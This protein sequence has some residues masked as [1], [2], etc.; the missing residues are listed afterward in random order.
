MLFDVHASVE[1]PVTVSP[2]ASPATLVT[3]VVSV[4]PYAFQTRPH[5][6]SSTSASE[7]SAGDA[8]GWTARVCVRCRPPPKDG[9]PA[10]VPVRRSA[11]MKMIRSQYAPDPRQT[12]STVFTAIAKSLSIDQFST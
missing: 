8:V 10:W 4:G 2:A 3:T 7:R 9:V 12:A 6:C 5:R 11:A 1:V